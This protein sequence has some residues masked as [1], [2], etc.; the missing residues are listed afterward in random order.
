MNPRQRWSPAIKL[1]PFAC[2]PPV[3]PGSSVWLWSRKRPRRG[4]QAGLVFGPARRDLAKE[5]EKQIM[6]HLK[7]AVADPQ[8]SPLRQRGF[9]LIELLVVIAIIAI[10]AAL[11][12]PA[13]GRAKLKTQ[14]VQC[15]NNSKQMMLVW[16]MYV[17]D[18]AN[19]V[20]SAYGNPDVW[21]PDSATMSL[22]REPKNGWP[23]L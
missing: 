2:R 4:C 15:M 10:L 6:K 23:Q 1:G 14:A 20:P 18:N 12:L 22:D 21:I 16:R 3:P 13:L 17:D 8:I 9:T 11:L 19:R 7:L 5:Y